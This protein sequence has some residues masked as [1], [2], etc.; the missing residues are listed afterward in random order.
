[1]FK[2]GDVRDTP[3][4]D[5][6]VAELIQ[7]HHLPATPGSVS[8]E[9]LRKAVAEAVNTYQKEIQKRDSETD[10]T[11]TV[12]RMHAHTGLA[13]LTGAVRTPVP[14]AVITLSKAHELWVAKKKDTKAPSTLLEWDTAIK[15]FI[16]IYG[17][18]DI[19]L[20][21]KA[22]FREFRDAL[23]Q[24]PRHRNKAMQKMTL[25]ELA[26]AYG[27]DTTVEKIGPAT[28]NKL[29]SAVSSV[30]TVALK[31]GYIDANPT[32]GI[33]ATAPPK[34]RT[35]RHP[36]ST[37]D[38]NAIFDSPVFTGCNSRDYR[39][40]PGPHVYRDDHFFWVPIVAYAT[41]ARL[42]ELG[43]LLVQDV[44]E[45]GGTWAIDIHE[46]DAGKRVKSDASERALPCHDLLH[47]VG[48]INWCKRRAVA[49]TATDRLF[50]TIDP[51]S[52][53]RITGKYSKWHGR[54]LRKVVG[55][56]GKLS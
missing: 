55:I 42:S 17:D 9:R 50:N 54:Y 35:K 1:M 24:V 12:A 32:T 46:R 43:A 25:P 37:D 28:V 15:R 10:P 27:A 8:H 49:S 34:R 39:G 26:E 7:K 40:R 13:A 53:G 33:Q 20:I 6:V 3:R 21:T 51:D 29:I 18:P 5:S 44:R 4:V 47:K 56:T 19:A 30:L 11:A 16:E 2:Q 38:V 36:F 23:L 45:T 41:G 48:F 31:D 52:K 14:A 22:A